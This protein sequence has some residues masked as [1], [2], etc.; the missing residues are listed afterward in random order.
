MNKRSY[1][2]LVGLVALTSSLQ[3]ATL[4]AADSLRYPLVMWAHDSNSLTEE[5]DAPLK[6]RGVLSEII[7]HAEES[8][9][10]FV[11]IA[12]KEKLTTPRLVSRADELTHLK[13]KVLSHSK[14]FVNVQDS[15]DSLNLQSELNALH[16]NIE[17]ESELEVLSAKLSEDLKS[18]LAN[19]RTFVVLSV[20]ESISIAETDR[21]LNSL[22]HDL[23]LTSTN[24]MLALLGTS[25]THHEAGFVSFMQEDARILA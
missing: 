17:S 20:H 21:I 11:L 19:K 25:G 12:V 6:S 3:F 7:S 15:L 5:I 18:S 8:N 22:E 4:Q 14:V 16:Y 13:D 24:F 10:Q 2:L 9:S 23:S 1:Q